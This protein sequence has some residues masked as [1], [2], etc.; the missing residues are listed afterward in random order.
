VSTATLEIVA[1]TLTYFTHCPHCETALEA[2]GVGR[3]AHT[4]EI[5]EYPEEVKAEYVQLCDWIRAASARYAGRLRIRLIDAQ[6]PE[7]LWKTLRHRARTYPLFVLDGTRVAVGWPQA[8]V[9]AILMEKLGPPRPL[10]EP[11]ATP[12]SRGARSATGGV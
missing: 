12:G 11:S 10:P 3:T 1:H 7:G 6:S 5:N 4:Q 9:D 8:Q 2:V